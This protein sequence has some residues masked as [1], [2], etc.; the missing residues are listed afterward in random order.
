MCVLGPCARC[1]RCSA[2]H[3]PAIRCM[4][5]LVACAL[6]TPHQTSILY[7][8][9]HGAKDDSLIL[10]SLATSARATPFSRFRSLDFK[11][12][13]AL[14]MPHIYLFKQNVS[15]QIYRHA[16]NGQ[17]QPAATTTDSLNAPTESD[18]R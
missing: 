2:S 10:V 16:K 5:F 11:C 13:N 15:T 7:Y 9:W 17:H 4:D 18:R 14:H 8:V 1:A 6:S 12:L 3:R